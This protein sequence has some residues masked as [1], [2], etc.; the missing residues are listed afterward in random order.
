MPVDKPFPSS[1]HFID[2]GPFLRVRGPTL[3]DE[4]P[5]LR[6]KPKLVSSLWLVGSPPIG[7]PSSDRL[8]FHVPKWDFPREYFNGK[9]REAKTSAG[10][11]AATGGC[12][13][14]EREVRGD[15]I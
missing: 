5:H 4:P 7:D 1:D 9:H 14:R 8:V 11:D 3:L 6:S 10:L 12:C 15:R 13:G 2:S